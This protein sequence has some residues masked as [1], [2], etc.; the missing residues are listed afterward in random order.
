METVH[1]FNA[2][3]LHKLVQMQNFEIF[4][5]WGRMGSEG[6]IADD[7][8]GLF[9]FF[10]KFFQI[11]GICTSININAIGDIGVENRVIQFQEGWLINKILHTIQAVQ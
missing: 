2:R 1:E 10:S 11:R 9:L 6:G 7:A 3:V 4:K 8:Y 5:Q